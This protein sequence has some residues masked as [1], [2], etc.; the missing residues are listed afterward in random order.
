M[1]STVQVK[2]YERLTIEAALT[3][4]YR[5]ALAALVLHPLVPS[6][7]V[8]QQLLETYIARHGALLPKL[9]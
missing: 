6:A 3:G 8:A 4:S 5:A 2:A 7:E 9:A 1:G